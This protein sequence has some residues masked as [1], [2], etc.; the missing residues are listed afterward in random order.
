MSGEALLS[1]L[2]G[3][4]ATG[5]GR[6]I[7]RCASHEDR[8]PSLSIRELDDGKIL[9]HCFAGCSVEDVLAALSLDFDSL[10][11]EKPIEH[12]KRERRPFNAHDVLACIA[13]EALLVAVAAGNL[14]Q[15]VV[16][17]DAD[18]ERLAVAV[19]RIQAGRGL[20]LGN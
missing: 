10:F 17:T 12:A 6:W 20:A 16:L 2:D 3:V 7:A 13:S 11:P 4:K 18:H 19:E 1:R 14:A 15:G 9:L 5:P 8:S